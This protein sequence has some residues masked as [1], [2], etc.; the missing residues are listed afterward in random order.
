[1]MGNMMMLAQQGTGASGSSGAT[2]MDMLTAIQ[3]PA[4]TRVWG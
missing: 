4:D 2:V 3:S 1:M